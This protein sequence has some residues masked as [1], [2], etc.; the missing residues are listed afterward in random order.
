MHRHL[1][2]LWIVLLLP[3]LFI[4]LSGA[5]NLASAQRRPTP[6]PIR[7]C[8]GQPVPTRLYLQEWMRLGGPDGAMGCP[9]SGVTLYD[10][11]HPERGGYVTFQNGTIGTSPDVWERGVVGAYQEGG[12]VV[13]DWTVSW[14]EP[15]PASHFNYDKFLVRWD[16]NGVNVGQSDIFA[17]MGA[18]QIILLKY[19]EDSH[20][21]SRGMYRIP[22]SK[23]DGT[24]RVVVEGCDVPDKFNPL[25]KSSCRQGWLRPITVQYR[26][27]AD[28]LPTVQWNQLD[29]A[30]GHV[31]PPT[32]V[33]DANSGFDDRAAAAILQSACQ[34]L[35]PTAYRH[36]ETFGEVLMGKMAY[37][38]Y[39]DSDHCPGRTVNNRDEAI[40]AL[41]RAGIDSNTGTNIGA[42]TTGDLPVVGV[43]PTGI[44]RTGEYDVILNAYI[45]IL[46]R[47]GE[48]LAP[49]VVTHVVNLLD[50]RGPFT[51]GDLHVETVVPESENHIMLIYTARYLTN[52]LLFARGRNQAYDN[53]RNGMDDW[54]L[55]HLR[56]FLQRDFLEYNARPYQ[57]YSMLALL[58]LYTY[59]SSASSRQCAEGVSCVKLAAQMILDYVSAKV[60]V[61]SNDSR[62]SV[63]FRRLIDH[64]D[65]HMFGAYLD[66]QTAFYI[67]YA[68]LTEMVANAPNS[69]SS[70]PNIG[71]EM[72]L[73]GLHAYRVP[74]PIIDLFV[75]NSHR[76]F[77]QSFHHAADE[78]YAGSPS[79]LI[80]AGGHYAPPPYKVGGALGRAADSGNVLPTTL[81]PTGRFES[82][83]DLL[84][85]KGDV[86]SG[87]ATPGAWESANMCVA[88]DF[89]CG[90]NPYIPPTYEK[91]N[92]PPGCV[93][94]DGPWTFF[95]E[96][97]KC[98][99]PGSMDHY[100][101]MRREG[102]VGFLEAYDLRTHSNID[103]PSFMA[104]VKKRN[105]STPCDV[106]GM[107]T[108]LT[109]SGHK[110]EFRFVNAHDSYVVS[111]DN[112]PTGAPATTLA[113]GTILNSDHDIGYVQ[114]DNPY[115]HDRLILDFR[116]AL[117]PV[118]S[119][120][121]G[122]SG[123]GYFPVEEMLLRQ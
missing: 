64:N 26:V 84:Q 83:D 104:G 30:T 7:D 89:A 25:D 107:N 68:G 6:K 45:P 78:I 53:R 119:F 67:A 98:A 74:D 13:V 39:F 118:R 71:Y 21:R 95:N 77:Y 52:Q 121:R 110:I 34:V 90:A 123:P 37:A 96:S 9:A 100:I 94:V 116:D 69:V 66:P 38:D 75:T 19:K 108:Y 5:L 85:F 56:E 22:G 29:L 59:A 114:I 103:F 27:D 8:A 14:D 62:R 16:V 47:Y 48:I 81:M 111:V 36:E 87:N 23:A 1:H 17:D 113:W 28:R 41:L 82:R 105:G 115:T 18:G 3:P 50:Q 32:S 15:W 51:E 112:K 65:P 57:D 11:G 40:G 109:T 120:V 91:G 92:R 93:E 43:I 72:L 33:A 86:V 2:R 61:S 55:H 70:H 54:M 20:L 4:C 63:P 24:Y 73:A 80:S 42:V 122:R 58:N 102:R 35:S 31:T 10:A 79:Y 12:D 106:N 49:S 117:N 88:P 97:R 101:A 44:F 99:A 76:S 46:Y 60:A